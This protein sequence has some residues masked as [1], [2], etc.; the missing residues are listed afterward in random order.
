VFN[1]LCG[2]VGRLTA[3]GLYE[4]VKK[5]DPP[6]MGITKVGVNGITAEDLKRPRRKLLLEQTAA[7]LPATL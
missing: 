1:L 3:A 2:R 7:R 4:F 5:S 6:V